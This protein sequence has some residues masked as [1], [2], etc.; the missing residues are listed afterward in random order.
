ALPA[1]LQAHFY[2]LFEGEPRSSRMRYNT[3]AKTVPLALPAELQAH[4]YELFEG[5]PRG[6][7]MRY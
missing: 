4:F 5:E 3:I 7:R 1:E 2:E 6:S